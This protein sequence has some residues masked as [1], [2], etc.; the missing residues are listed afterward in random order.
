MRV[1]SS[2]SELSEPS[3][4]AVPP[5]AMDW[6]APASAVGGLLAAV[7]AANWAAVSKLPRRNTGYWRLVPKFQGLSSPEVSSTFTFQSA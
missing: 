4:V 3:R 6:L 1:C 2:G 5:L 7:W